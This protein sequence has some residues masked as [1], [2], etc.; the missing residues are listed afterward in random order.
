MG[1]SREEGKKEGEAGGHNTVMNRNCK[2][3]LRG[4][5]RGVEEMAQSQHS[6]WSLDAPG[7]GKAR[8]RMTAFSISDVGSCAPGGWKI[9]REIG[10]VVT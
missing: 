7:L 8:G 9:P 6:S 5:A 2:N 4:R 10:W 1:C 3:G